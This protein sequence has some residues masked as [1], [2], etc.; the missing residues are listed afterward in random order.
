MK[1]YAVCFTLA[2][3]SLS[4]VLAQS[5]AQTDQQ[6]NGDWHHRFRLSSTTF[7]DGGTLPL[8]MVLGSDNCTFVSGGGDQSPELSWTHAPRGTR[9]FVVTMFDVTASFTHWGM[10]NISPKTR[11]LPENAGVAGSPYGQQVFNDF[12]LGAE[13]DGPCPPPGFAP[14]NHDYVI[15]VFALD[16]E[17]HLISSPPNFPADAETLYRAMFD[18]VLQSASIHGFF[19]TAD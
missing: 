19:S 6:A 8:S 5:S 3:A 7:T 2:L 11:E 10:Y 13:Y 4:I 16:T 15:T 12:G 9:S 1:N 18:H 14:V 17:L